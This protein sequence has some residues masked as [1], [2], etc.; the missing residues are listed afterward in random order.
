[1]ANQVYNPCDSL[2]VTIDNI[3]ELDKL[4]PD[5]CI[6]NHDSI[7]FMICSHRV[8]HGPRVLLF[9]FLKNILLFYC[10][11][12]ANPSP[13]AF[14]DSS[15][16]YMD[17]V[18]ELDELHINVP[19]LSPWLLV[20]ERF[21]DNRM[22]FIKKVNQKGNNLG[23]INQVHDPLRFIQCHYGQQCRAHRVLSEYVP[24]ISWI[25]VVHDLLP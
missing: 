2:N 23:A 10:A 13:I 18:V 12:S 4:Y 11:F 17:N 15:N 16:V 25:I 5:M 1:L 14:C 8:I 9:W 7:W 22:F 21:S 20:W 6:H 3:V 24:Y 19:S